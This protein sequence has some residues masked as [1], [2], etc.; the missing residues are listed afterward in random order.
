MGSIAGFVAVPP[1]Q[2]GKDTLLRMLAAQRRRGD[3]LQPLY[4][5]HGT[6][7]GQGSHRTGSG[8][9]ARAACDPGIHIAFDGELFN[10][11][12]LRSLVQ[13]HTAI[14][15]SS[16]P[17]A[18]IA[19][20]YGVMGD[21]LLHHLDG[22]FAFA[23]WDAARRR[24]LLARDRFGVRPLFY[25]Q[26]GAALWFS[27]QASGLLAARPDLGALDLHGLAQT[28]ACWAPLG[29]RSALRGV[30]NLP[31]G[32]LMVVDESATAQLRSWW[33]PMFP[34]SNGA[35]QG[36]V[37]SAARQLRTLLD[38][39]VRRRMPHDGTAAAAYLS[40]GLDSSAIAAMMA[41]ASTQP[42]RTFSVAF[43][44]AEFDESAHQ[45][46]MAEH[47]GAQHETLR[48]SP[49]D[50]GN[51]F[52]QLVEQVEMPLLRTAG[53]PL[54][55]LAAQLHRRG[56]AVALTGEGADEI[57]A[58]Y[59]LFKE[60]K[61]RRFWARQPDSRLRPLLLGRLYGY[62]AHSPVAN[63][64][65]AQVFFGQGME[66]LQ[67]PVF[68]HVPRWNTSQRALAFFSSGRRE[69]LRGFD[70]AVEVEKLLPP[71]IMDWPPLSR[72]QFVEMQTMSSGYLLPA[73]GD[74]PSM[75]HGVHAH[76]PFLDHQLVE[77]ANS[78]PPR[79]KL[80]GLTE[81]YVLREAVAD[82]L[83]A[84]VMARTKQP[85][86][87]PDANSFFTAG[88]PLDY[89]ADLFSESRLRSAGYFD[90]A[91]TARLFEKCRKG[92]ATGFGDNQAFVGIL[93]TMLLDDH[94]VRARRS[95]DGY[96][97]LEHHHSRES[98]DGTAAIH[99]Y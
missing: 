89:V 10:I 21:E 78:L 48:I 73:Q 5:H 39:A 81:K 30:S 66:Y 76:M 70:P 9:D 27:S 47:I 12:A 4:V 34:K 15:A 3:Q 43:S 67:R 64:A 18:L 80:R 38:D 62:L 6:A 45:Q 57:L 28:F 79:W 42:L 31:P 23:L 13:R 60:A 54:M 35:T 84:Q 97:N 52:P 2:S 74:R 41:G 71:G 88:E 25:S 50:I 33:Q 77:F 40:G 56:I 63:P 90:V 22:Q 95:N 44:D 51:A 1:A 26:A 61:V 8:E 87:A 7:I 75:M 17:S 92:R 99:T 53:V 96:A 94:F 83:P 91:R 14:Y 82:L 36:C 29:G 55:L 19:Q 72:D 58:G 46:L 85:F 69:Q 32:H 16:T 98:T 86:R 59:D 11:D 65:Y 24:L 20:L 68:A 37:G 93:S 49:G